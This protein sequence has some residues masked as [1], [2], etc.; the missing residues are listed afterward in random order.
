MQVQEIMS[1]TVEVVERHDA[2]NQV[3]DLMVTTKLRHV[4]VV[5]NGAIVAIVAQRDIFQAMLSSTM[6]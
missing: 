2:L 1:T 5:E 4:P 3:D 6:G